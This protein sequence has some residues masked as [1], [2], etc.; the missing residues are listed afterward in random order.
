MPNAKAAF[1]QDF[2]NYTPV[3]HLVRR[4]ALLNCLK[5]ILKPAYHHPGGY[6]LL[7]GPPGS[8]KTTILQQAIAECGSGILYVS[9][10]HDGD[11]SDSLYSALKISKFCDST[12]RSYVRVPSR[13][14]P[15]DSSARFKYALEILKEAATEMFIEDK[16]PPIVFDTTEQTLLHPDGV[17]NIQLLQDLAKEISD[18]KFLIFLFSSNKNSVPSIMQTQSSASRMHEVIKMGDI[19]D[20]EAVNFLTCMC[21]N[22]TKDAITNAVRLVGGRFSD[23]DI[24]AEHINAGIIDG[25]KL[26]GFFFKS[27][28]AVIVALPS[29][30]RTVMYEIARSILKS[31]GNKITRDE[32]N[33]LMDTF[34]ISDLKLIEKTNVLWIDPHM[35]TFASRITQTYWERKISNFTVLVTAD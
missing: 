33:V 15:D 14:C 22:A 13:S 10:N 6:Y 31:S 27:I 34:N 21:P 7:V 3:K 35:V 18:K 12:L 4:P 24:A 16:Y 26:E 11:V 25:D 23:L 17:K 32:F 8:G 5:G 1:K 20:E 9:V 30:I 29:Q 2:Q 28:Q 19:T